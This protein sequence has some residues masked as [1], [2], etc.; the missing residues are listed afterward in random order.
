MVGDGSGVLI[1]ETHEHVQARGAGVYATVA[2][3]GATSDAMHP[4]S[5]LDNAHGLTRAI[6]MAITDA[7]IEKNAIDY[8]SAHRTSTPGG[9][10]HE[11]TAVNSV[12]GT[13]NTPYVTAMRS[14]TGHTLGAA[15][16]IEAVIAVQ[17]INNITSPTINL[18]R[19]DEECDITVVTEP[20]EQNVSTVLS[21]SAG[22]GRTNGTVIFTDV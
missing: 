12:F 10:V 9:D 15:G 7:G 17:S 19:R 8:V 22:F 20:I 4:I 2:G 3:L 1:I 21:N 16:V 11:A 18:E 5:P 14:Q 13:E 6:E